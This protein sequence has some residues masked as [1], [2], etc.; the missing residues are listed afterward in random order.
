[1]PMLWNANLKTR[2][3]FER[4][5]RELVELYEDGEYSERMLDE[6]DV[7]AAAAWI[8]PV[9]ETRRGRMHLSQALATFSNTTPAEFKRVFDVPDLSRNFDI[10]YDLV[11]KVAGRNVGMAIMKDVLTETGHIGTVCMRALGRLVS[12]AS[13]YTTPHRTHELAQAAV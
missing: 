5:L 6:A 10:N 9:S 11:R 3:D 12:P 7:L 2:E 8:D 13:R 4:R 1:M